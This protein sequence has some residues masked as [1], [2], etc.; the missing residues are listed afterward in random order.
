MR[1]LLLLLMFPSFLHAAPPGD[2]STTCTI[3]ETGVSWEKVSSKKELRQSCKNAVAP[4]PEHCLCRILRPGY[5]SMFITPG[6]TTT[7]YARKRK[8]VVA[9]PGMVSAT[10]LERR[11]GVRLTLILQLEEISAEG[12]I[13]AEVTST[14]YKFIRALAPATVKTSCGQVIQM[15]AN[16][17]IGLNPDGCWH[18]F[19]KDYPFGPVEAPPQVKTS[20]QVEA[21]VQTPAQT[22]TNP[23]QGCNCNVSYAIKPQ[24]QSE[25]VLYLLLLLGGVALLR[26]RRNR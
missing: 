26:R 14:G 22:P 25:M 13:R 17:R 1:I 4:W 12:E 24:W 16:M 6:V 9:V 7:V 20:A 21:H 2:D 23:S 3:T 10:P 19:Q 11:G 15:S 8:A 18:F 5:M